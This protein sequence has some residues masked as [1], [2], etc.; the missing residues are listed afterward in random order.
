MSPARYVQVSVRN[1]TV[2]LFS[3][4]GGRNRMPSK[5]QNAFK[6]DYDPELDTSPELDPDAA[7]YYLM[8]IGFL[9]WMIE[10]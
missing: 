8:I 10:L 7:C 1:C 5:A 9:R 4:Y 6:M 2:H 3:N